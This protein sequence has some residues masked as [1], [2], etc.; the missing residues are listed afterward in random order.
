MLYAD[1]PAETDHVCDHPE[2]DVSIENTVCHK[3]FTI[4]GN[5]K[6]REKK[7]EGDHA[8]DIAGDPVDKDSVDQSVG[9]HT[10]SQKP[11]GNNQPG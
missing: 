7:N 11:D 10:Q 3:R 4:I 5:H 2:Q 6:D 1:V 9:K 8:E